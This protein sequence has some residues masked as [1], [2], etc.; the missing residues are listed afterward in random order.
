M[1]RRTYSEN[2]DPNDNRLQPVTVKSPAINPEVISQPAK[3]HHSHH[4]L[5]VKLELT[6]T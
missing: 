2:V 5:Q 1:K 6:A 3:P 4:A